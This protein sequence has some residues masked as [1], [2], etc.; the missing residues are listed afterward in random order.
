MTREERT[1]AIIF[2]I[3]FL[4]GLANY[5]QS[6]VFIVPF[7]LFPVFTFVISLYFALSHFKEQKIETLL[8]AFATLFNLI[9]S[10]FF[11]S[12]FLNEEELTNFS[13][14]ALLGLGNSLLLSTGVILCLIDS[15]DR[16]KN[17]F[18]AIA[19][20]IF[21]GSFL[22]NLTWLYTLALLCV[23]SVSIIF[24]K[25]KKYPI[26]LMALT[27]LVFDVVERLVRFY[28]G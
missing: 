18:V 24:P 25:N 1:V 14:G 21:L 3:N 5:V 2:L 26:H 15:R 16:K 13:L 17:I 23:I 7:P 6:G 20:L 12:I 4:F 22:L 27:L 19:G 28:Y 10:Q 11:L 8:I 9:Q